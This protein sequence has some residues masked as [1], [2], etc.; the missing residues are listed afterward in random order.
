[1]YEL[2]DFKETSTKKTVKALNKGRSAMK[3]YFHIILS[4]VL[5]RHLCR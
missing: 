3:V 5:N 4:K 2:F 1:M